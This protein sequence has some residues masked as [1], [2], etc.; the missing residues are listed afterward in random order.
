MT[1]L[2]C[3]ILAAALGPACRIS[4]NTTNTLDG[5]PLAPTPAAPTTPTV[6]APTHPTTNG[7]RTPDPAPGAQLPFPTYG[8]A[9][10]AGVSTSGVASSCTT[11]TYLDALVDAL[12][13]RDTRW[14]YVCSNGN[15]ATVSRDAVGYH[16]TA[17]AE[18]S[19]VTGLYVV[20]VIQNLC[21]SPVAQ[22]LPLSTATL[23]P[24]A[25]WTGKGRF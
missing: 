12:R 6:P 14:G 4:V 11:S 8:G 25:A 19:G 1:R 13:L 24:T 5:N 17:G 3:L 15:C 22:W 7:Y 23:D 18:A 21:S 9:V 16:A 10:A 2:A 20:D